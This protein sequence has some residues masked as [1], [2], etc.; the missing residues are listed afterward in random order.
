MTASA[1]LH[2]QPSTKNAATEYADFVNPQWVRLL[3]LLGMDTEY[4][5]CSGATLETTD[6]RQVLDCL[7][8]YC[9]YNTGH[10]HPYILDALKQE[11]DRCGPT[12]LQSHIP[13]LAGE[14]AGRLCHLAGGRLQKVF[15]C[16]SGSEGVE[17]AIKFARARTGRSG[18]LS[19]QGS[20]HGLTTGALSL[21]G[22][23]SWRANFG[24]LL[25]EVATVP[26]NDLPALEKQLATRKFAAFFVEPVQGEGG[27]RLPDADYLQQAQDLCHQYGSLFVADE[28]QTGLYRTGKFLASHH[29]GV[30]P[31]MVILA[32]ALSGGLVPVAAVLMTEDIYDAVY[33]SLKRAI[34]HAS[35]FSENA[36]SMRAGLATL[37]VLAAENLG[38]RSLHTGEALRQ[39]LQD[40][41]QDFEMVEE[42]RGLGLFNGIVFR[43]PRQLSLRVAFESCKAIH[44]GLFGQ[45]LVRRLFNQHDLLTQICGNDF[46]VLKVAPPLVIDAAERDRIV[47][48]ITET[49]SAVH[50]SSTFWKDALEIARRA[51]N[52]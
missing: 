37:D 36:L 34:L 4:V 50:S 2:S 33:G 41:L 17:S 8:G 27:I 6:G 13:G 48:A 15:F 31:D 19:C 20:F 42:V 5:R 39:Q 26:F 16:S 51:V 43:A 21:M 14:L 49:V 35:T 23:C 29:Y 40:A 11:L 46:M 52:L 30:A 10:N 24:P 44:P 3:G 38:G 32:K 45:M 25:Q 12:M 18:L 28:V 22:E 1:L 47:A 9:V 7:S